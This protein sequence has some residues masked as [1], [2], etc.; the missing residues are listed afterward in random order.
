MI[1]TERANLDNK[2]CPNGQSKSEERIA[3]TT[4]DQKATPGCSHG[5]FASLLLNNLEENAS[6]PWV[7]REIL[8]RFCRTSELR[9]P[10]GWVQIEE[11]FPNSSAATGLSVA[12]GSPTCFS[13]ARLARHSEVLRA[14]F[15]SRL[16]CHSS[17]QGVR[18]GDSVVSETGRDDSVAT[19]ACSLVLG[20]GNACDPT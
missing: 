16:R 11:D 3:A 18:H 13:L 4:A 17:Q 20:E 6:S 8:H 12:T 14:R 19:Y 10:A 15:C 1:Q 5:A 9:H 2:S 7:L